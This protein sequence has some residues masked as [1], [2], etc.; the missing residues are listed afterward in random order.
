MPVEQ[1]LSRIIELIYDA[2]L[3]PERWRDALAAS[4]AFVRCDVGTLYSHDTR[5]GQATFHRLCGLS[6]Y[7][8]K[9]YLEEYAAANPLIQP[10]MAADAGDVVAASRLPIWD[11][12][13][14]SRFF[15]INSNK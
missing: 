3:E 4:S 6:P 7:Y 14:R 2:A 9:Q 12:F 1:T 10:M 8:E 15:L 11:E 13:R 5:L